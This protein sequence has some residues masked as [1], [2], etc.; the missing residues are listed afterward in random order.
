MEVL[1]AGARQLDRVERAT[2]LDGL[3]DALRRVIR[4]IVPLGRL[5]DALH[6]TWLGH[7]VHPALTD[8]PVGA[9]VAAAVLDAVPGQGWSTA[10][11][12]PC[13]CSWSS[14]H[15]RPGRWPR[16]PCRSSTTSRA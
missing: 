1:G 10:A 8:V 6:G 2:A 13:T 9:W 15:T 11:R 4:R 7:P 3:V 12:A 5:A 16:A 14:A